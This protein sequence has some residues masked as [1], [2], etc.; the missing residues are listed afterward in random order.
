MFYLDGVRIYGPLEYKE[1]ADNTYDSDNY[2][3]S[4]VDAHIYE[5]RPMIIGNTVD[6]KTANH[7]MLMKYK[8]GGEVDLSAG[9]STVVET[10]HG[11]VPDDAKKNNR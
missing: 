1:N 6:G 2:L 8:A 3:E 5:I 7:A 11:A 9:G 4:E 10:L